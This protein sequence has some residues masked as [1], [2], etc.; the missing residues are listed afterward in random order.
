MWRVAPG[1]GSGIWRVST[2]NGQETRFGQLCGAGL[3]LEGST[4]SVGNVLRGSTVTTQ[5]Q[6]RA[7]G[8][9]R[10]TC[11]RRKGTRDSSGGTFPRNECH[12]DCW[13]GTVEF[14]GYCQGVYRPHGDPRDGE[15]DF[16]G[17]TRS[18]TWQS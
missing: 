9:R 15:F 1:H 3:V 17:E 13:C 6:H 12:T 11:V 14:Y 10:L 8:G 4:A 2:P 7:G 18:V 16:V 5:L